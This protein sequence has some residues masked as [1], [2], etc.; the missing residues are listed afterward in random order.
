MDSNHWN[1]ARHSLGL[2]RCVINTSRY[3]VPV[4]TS[5][6]SNDLQ[7]AT[8]HALA[9]VIGKH[10]ILR[11]GIVGE[12]TRSPC[13]VYI[14]RL[15]LAEM[16]HW[17]R[18]ELPGSGTPQHGVDQTNQL[19]RRLER[20]HD[21]LWERLSERPGWKLLVQENTQAG[22][23]ISLDISLCFHH[24]YMDGKSST[25]FH[26]DLLEA[27]NNQPDNGQ[28]PAEFPITLT[29][30][31]PPELPEPADTLIPFRLSFWYVVRTVWEEVLRDA[32]VPTWLRQAPSPGTTTP[33]TGRPMDPENHKV[34]LR[35][36]RI[37]PA[38]LEALLRACRANKATLTTLLHALMAASLASHLSPGEA[39]CFKGSCP[40]SL[41]RYASPPFD[42][43]S[44]L[45]CLVASCAHII[46][47]ETVA[48][49]RTAMETTPA[50]L[51]DDD[52][53]ADRHIWTIARTFSK[54]LREKVAQ[55]PRDDIVALTSWVPDWHEFFTSKFG[56]ARGDTF[57]VSNIGS[58]S[59]QAAGHQT[60]D[61]SNGDGNGDDED[62][63]QAEA[64][65]WHID[66]AILSQGAT[67]VG[68][69]FALNVAGVKGDGVW[70]TVSWQEGAV[71]P[72][73]L[74]DKVVEDLQR[75]V[76]GY[77]TKARFTTRS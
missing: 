31:S 56:K 1:T 49:L 53:N 40:I 71:E 22:T 36:V 35:C 69:A 10:S 9:T 25:V 55:L 77:P 7:V 45:H 60:K 73:G 43:E 51:E 11:V 37:S 18:E 38:S 57:E 8:Q 16:M 27:L 61:H 63:S 26:R 75:W 44:T 3:T 19:L 65:R 62:G 32:V 15:E 12:D 46:D 28:E 64:R 67:P 42:P 68:P 13:F 70:V 30:S 21:E 17:T 34:N 52:G 41:S 4:G 14:A 72:E 50:G 29:F 48:A 24:A 76:D 6:K 2:Y 39:S 59:R 74:L 5:R 47:P 66:R 58:M 33:W 23:T 20:R 54:I